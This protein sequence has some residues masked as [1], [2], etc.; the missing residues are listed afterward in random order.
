MKDIAT[1][2]TKMMSFNIEM[3]IYDTREMSHII[4]LLKLLTAK[5]IDYLNIF[6]TFCFRIKKE[7]EV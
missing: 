4:L 2:H 6:H 3:A 5:I 7:L 1:Y